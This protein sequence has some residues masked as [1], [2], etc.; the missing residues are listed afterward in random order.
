ML[1]PP[2]YSTPPAQFAGPGSQVCILPLHESSGV[3]I[4]NLWLFQIMVCRTTMTKLP[5]V[6]RWA[7]G[8]TWSSTTII[9]EAG[10]ARAPTILAAVRDFW[11]VHLWTRG[12]VNMN[13]TLWTWLVDL[14]MW[15]CDL[16]NLTCGLVNVIVDL[17]MWI[18]TIYACLCEYELYVNMNVDLWIKYMGCWLGG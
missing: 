10:A 7:D 8:W 5:E 16:V 3:S 2:Q 14:W 4:Y 11:L 12:F 15:T 18:W 13:V 17:W 9:R 6:R 1:I